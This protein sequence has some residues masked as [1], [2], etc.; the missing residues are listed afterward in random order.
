LL[1]CF[2]LQSGDYSILKEQKAGEEEFGF[3]TSLLDE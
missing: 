1:Q 3:F 2:L